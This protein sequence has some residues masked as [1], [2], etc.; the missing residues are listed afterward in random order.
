MP[1][2]KTQKNKK[3]YKLGWN[4]T[5]KIKN[6]PLL[7]DSI[8]NKFQL[9][10]AINEQLYCNVHGRIPP[11]VVRQACT[12]LYCTVQYR[13]VEPDLDRPGSAFFFADPGFWIRIRIWIVKMDRFCGRS[14]SAFICGSR[15]TFFKR[16]IVIWRSWIRIQIHTFGSCRIG[17]SPKKYRSATLV[18]YC[19][20][21]YLP[22]YL[23]TDRPN[24]LPT[25]EQNTPYEHNNI[26]CTI[27]T[28]LSAAFDTID[29]TKVLD[30]LQYY[31]VVGQEYNIFKSFLSN[32]TQ[33]VE[34]D[35]FKSTILNSP[36]CSVV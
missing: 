2:K 21:S 19:T 22:T 31:G 29:N 5:E 25:N 9:I 27:A 32:R 11:E 28:D 6:V 26:S 1:T 8:H 23:P 4:T 12:V 34:I 17:I 35:S 18:L 13:V 14:R 33:Y 10:Y 3:N 16:N 7:S 36:L 24:D 15:S 20:W 30:K